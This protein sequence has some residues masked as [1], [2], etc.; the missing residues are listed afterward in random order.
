MPYIGLGFKQAHSVVGIRAYNLA[1][2]NK[3]APKKQGEIS[4]RPSTFMK[5]EEKP[6]GI[7]AKAEEVPAK[8]QHFTNLTI[9]DKTKTSSKKTALSKTDI[10]NKIVRHY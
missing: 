9:N 6:K 5:K 10:D 8:L 3:P 7:Y 1:S 4:L 2:S